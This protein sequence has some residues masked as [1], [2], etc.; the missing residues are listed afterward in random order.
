VSWLASGFAL[1]AGALLCSVLLDYFCW[2]SFETHAA[3][4]GPIIDC[5]LLVAD[6]V[7]IARF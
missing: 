5:L 6:F 3:G 4:W 7:L 2:V 1:L